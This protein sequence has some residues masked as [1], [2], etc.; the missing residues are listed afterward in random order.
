[1]P[2]AVVIIASSSPLALSGGCRFKAETVVTPNNRF[3]ADLRTVYN[4]HGVR[5]VVVQSGTVGAF[6]FQTM[7]VNLTVALGLL[8]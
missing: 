5:I 2:A 4:M 1:M 6:N 8:S 3:P 7:L